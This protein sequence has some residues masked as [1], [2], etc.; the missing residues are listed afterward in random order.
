MAK[1]VITENISDGVKILTA[2]LPVGAELFFGFTLQEW[3]YIASIVASI[4]YI[5]DKIPSFVRGVYGWIK[6]K[7][8]SSRC[9]NDASDGE[10]T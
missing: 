10:S 1:D 5:V 9:S 3:M 7:G 8:S 2:T 4:F 6:R